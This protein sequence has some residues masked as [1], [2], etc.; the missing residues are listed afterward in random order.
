MQIG[1]NSFKTTELEYQL[2][3]NWIRTGDWVLD[4]G[5]NVGHYSLRLSELCGDSGRVLAFEPVPLTF[6]LLASN[7][8]KARYQNVTI[9][10]VAVSNQTEIIRMNVP[11]DG[12]EVKSRLNYYRSHVTSL[13]DLNILSISIDSLNICHTVRLV[14]IDVEGHEIYVLQG[15][16]QLLKRDFPILIVEGNSSQVDSYLAS[17][18]YSSKR[19]QGSVNQIFEC[20]PAK[21]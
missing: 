1:K 19:L 7:V 21:L 17:I 15:M 5:A 6:D 14:K 10:N 12:L 18:G 20:F 3:A 9:F 11:Q 16:Q 4:I 13:G 8:S 2:L